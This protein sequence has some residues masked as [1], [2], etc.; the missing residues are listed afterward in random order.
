MKGVIIKIKNGMVIILLCIVTALL[1]KPLIITA[2][3]KPP[4]SDNDALNILSSVLEV[5]ISLDNADLV[6]K[7]YSTNIREEGYLIVC[8]LHNMNLKEMVRDLRL[9]KTSLPIKAEHNYDS[10]ELNDVINRFYDNDELFCRYGCDMLI[11]GTPHIASVFM[12]SLSQDGRL[13]L[14]MEE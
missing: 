8:D 2:L 13:L 7:E 4:L 9:T 6:W 12:I 11:D 14:Y 1:I 10:E 5:E 3:F